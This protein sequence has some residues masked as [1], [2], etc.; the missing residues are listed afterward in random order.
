MK[1]TLIFVLAALFFVIAMVL[2]AGPGTPMVEIEQ[3]LADR[4]QQLAF[5]PPDVRFVGR[6]LQCLPVDHPIDQAE[7]PEEAFERDGRNREADVAVLDVLRSLGLELTPIELPEFPLQAMLLTLDVEAA[8]AFDAD[9][10]SN[11]RPVGRA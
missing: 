5:E 8:A 6:D 11:Q 2:S 1:K 4:R 9:I 3:A 7:R 10:K